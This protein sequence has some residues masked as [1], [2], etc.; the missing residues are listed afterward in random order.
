MTFDISAQYLNI[1]YYVCLLTNQKLFGDCFLVWILLVK[2]YFLQASTFRFANGAVTGI[3]VQ[4][5]MYP[6]EIVKT[7]IMTLPAKSGK[8]GVWE[9]GKKI[10]NDNGKTSALNFYKGFLPAI[11]GVIPFAGLELGCSKVCHQ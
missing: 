4:T 2:S 10:L 7:R 6:F 1:W 3:L 5:V 8:M 11:I 9:A